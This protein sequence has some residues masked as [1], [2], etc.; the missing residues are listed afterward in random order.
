[1]KSKKMAKKHRMMMK[2]KRLNHSLW[3]TQL[4]LWCCHLVSNGMVADDVI[5]VSGGHFYDDLIH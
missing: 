1:V 3:M 5:I 2:K 4:H